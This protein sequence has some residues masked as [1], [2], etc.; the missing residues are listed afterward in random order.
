MYLGDMYT[1]PASPLILS[2]VRPFHPVQSHL[3]SPSLPSPPLLHLPSILPPQ[4][5]QDWKTRRGFCPVTREDKL[6]Y[7][8]W[9]WLVL[10]LEKG[11]LE[12][13]SVEG[14][15][16]VSSSCTVFEYWQEYL[17]VKYLLYSWRCCEVGC[18]LPDLTIC[19]YRPYLRRYLK[20]PY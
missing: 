8:S 14:G 15:I 2:L 16:E 19:T 11:A 6:R 20:V 7:D 10:V 13:R 12:R 17:G 5:Q 9:A 4:A 18:Y 1:F 3:T